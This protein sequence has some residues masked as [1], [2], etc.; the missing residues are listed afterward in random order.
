M[1]DS[2]FWRDLAEEFRAL[3]D[4]QGSL[5]AEWTI[6]HGGELP[7][8]G[9]LY[10]QPNRSLRIHFEVVARTAGAALNPP[11]TVN[12]LDA[13]LD[14]LKQEREPS[15]GKTWQI[16]NDFRG[17]LK[18]YIREVCRASADLCKILENRALE[19][20]HSLEPNRRSLMSSELTESLEQILFQGGKWGE[21]KRDRTV[22]RSESRPRAPEHPPASPS[23]SE[24]VPQEKPI[25]V[26]IVQAARR[27]GFEA[28]MDR[29]NAIAEIVSR[30]APNWRE[31]PASW[32]KAEVLKSICVDLDTATSS[33]QSG[34]YEV[35][36]SWSTGKPESLRG[37]PARSWSEALKLA[38]RK[39][40]S[41]QIGSSLTKVRRKEGK[42]SEHERHQPSRSHPVE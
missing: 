39:L 26:P 14:F 5:Y 18:G 34:L 36:G 30:H 16:V 19:V 20:E 12:L 29:H 35:P 8:V 33:D 13:W 22:G 40:I 37:A 23:G 11:K 3:P 15:R 21:P 4:P 10:G 25:L 28:D 32:K 42:E 7:V 9:A 41:D 2:D 17:P 6:M 31:N 27:H 24:T 1:D 38:P